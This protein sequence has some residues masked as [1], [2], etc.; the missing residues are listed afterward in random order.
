MLK[1]KL[2][3]TFFSLI[4]L[5]ILTVIIS[6]FIGDNDYKNL[7]YSIYII[8][9][10]WIA[11]IIGIIIII[12][13]LFKYRIKTTGYLY[14]FVGTLNVYMC[15]AAAIFIYFDSQKILSWEIA[16]SWPALLIGA[17]I[18]ADV[19]CD[20]ITFRDSSATGNS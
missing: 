10:Y 9:G 16:K 18:L 4:S 2:R 20:I 3:I 11:I 17:F 5:I 12:I 6:L 8:F 14:N 13:R 15:I 19:Y 7:A 1:K